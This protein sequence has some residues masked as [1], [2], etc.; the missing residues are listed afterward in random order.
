MRVPIVSLSAQFAASG[1]GGA[2]GKERTKQVLFYA[3]ATVIRGYDPQFKLTLGMKPGQVRMDR[4]LSGKAPVLDSHDT[5]SGVKAQIGVIE[6]A[7]I[8][9]GKGY[10]D[11]RFSERDEVT[12]IWEDIQ[13]GIIRNA[14][15]G[16]KIHK[17]QDV[18]EEDDKIK[19]YL[20]VDW[21]PL[22]I[23]IVPIGA[24]PDAGFRAGAEVQFSE[25]EVVSVDIQGAIQ[26]RKG[27]NMSDGKPITNAGEQARTTN[28]NPARDPATV[29]AAAAATKTDPPLPEEDL[30]KVS[31]L[32]ATK[33]KGRV[34]AIRKTCQAC[35]LEPSFGDRHIDADTSIEEFRRLAIDEKARRAAAQPQ[36]TGVHAEIVQEETE[37]RRIGLAG[38]LLE[39]FKPGNWRFDPE[40]HAFVY[41]KGGRQKLFEPSRQFV[42]LTL[43]DVAKECLAAQGI[44]WQS[45]NRTEIAQLAFQSTSDFPGILANVANKSLRSGY[46]M[47][48]SQWRL[49]AAR[50]TA[51]DFKT[52]SELTLDG[53]ARLE[54]IKEDGEYHRGKLVEGKETWQLATY[55]KIIGITRQAIINDDLG[56]F[57][58][59]PFLL[60]QEVAMLEADMVIGIITDNAALAD[61]YDLFDGTNHLNVTGSGAAISI[62]SLGA[63]R[64]LLM[65]Q[66]STGAK[67]LNITPRF[68]LAPATQGQLAEQ[69]CSANYQATEQANI[70][71]L[72]GRLTPVIESRLDAGTETTAGDTYAWYL[73]GDPNSPNG[74]VVIYAYLEGQEGPY[75]E[76]RQG[77]DID[78]VEIKIRHDFAAAAVDYRGAVKNAGH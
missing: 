2:N 5:Y 69:Y 62:P 78:G 60:G 12:P 44:R 35:G 8:D 42:G 51:P 28:L 21:E 77:F 29:N 31:K 38:A 45:R 25:A 32:G 49:I 55:G 65:T 47:Y 30:E 50:R 57:T 75:T 19:S 73:F 36:V 22:E 40:T 23:S 46:E 74:T 16:A 17:L 61:G 70:N 59:T 34:V 18:S 43:L 24:D 9:K 48:E 3:G 20:A 58:R 71:P 33:E 26:A 53:S 52:V 14:S 56:A 39:R 15:V 4:L 64:V 7:W 11:L 1:N 13:N 54:L 63:A 67:P 41:E 68:L 6:K 72:A 27:V 66:K 76:N 10:A 37:M